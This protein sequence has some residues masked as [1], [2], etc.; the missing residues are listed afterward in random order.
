MT[1]TLTLTFHDDPGH[2]WLEIPKKLCDGLGVVLTPYSYIS[3]D[4]QTYYAEEDVD[5]GAILNALKEMGIYL[6]VKEKYSDPCFIRN[7]RHV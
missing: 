3:N 1:A 5:A 4:G 7:L 2:A 6:E